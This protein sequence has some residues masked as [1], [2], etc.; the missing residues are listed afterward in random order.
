M[1]EE[2]RL[3]KELPDLMTPAEVAAYLQVTVMEVYRMRYSGKLSGIKL[4]HK[5]LRFRRQDVEGFVSGNSDQ[6]GDDDG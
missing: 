2:T 6:A 4:G 5:T 1:A 3:I